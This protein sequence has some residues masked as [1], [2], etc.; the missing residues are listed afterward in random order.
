MPEDN[1]FQVGGDAPKG[2]GAAEATAAPVS[3]AKVAPAADDGEIVQTPKPAA[4]KPT[5]AELEAAKRKAFE[6]QQMPVHT[7]SRR[8]L[9]NQ[10]RLQAERARAEQLETL[11]RGHE[12]V[13]ELV[14]ENAALKA[15]LEAL[16]KAKGRR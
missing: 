5:E 2:A 11:C 4:V 15:E 3:P 13:R 8:D 6:A 9:E 10:W 1:D 7:P 14:A 16:K 12:V